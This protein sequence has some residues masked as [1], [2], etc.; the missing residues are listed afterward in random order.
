MSEKRGGDL[1]SETGSTM[2]KLKEVEA[3]LKILVEEELK[4]CVT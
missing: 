1:V 3:Q 4:V 2:S